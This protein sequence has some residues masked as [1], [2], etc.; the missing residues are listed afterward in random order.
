MCQFY[1]CLSCF[2]V[3]K[4]STKLE[5][6]LTEQLILFMRSDIVYSVKRLLA[7]DLEVMYVGSGYNEFEISPNPF[8]EAFEVH[9]NASLGGMQVTT[10]ITY[11]W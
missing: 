11:N 10:R 4:E 7:G 1:A 9:P 2:P 6:E 8:Q 3:E 5:R